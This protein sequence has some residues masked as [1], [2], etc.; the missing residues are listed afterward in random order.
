MRQQR[1]LLGHGIHIPQLQQLL[2]VYLVELG[3]LSIHDSIWLGST[4]HRDSAT[5]RQVLVLVIVG[6][7]RCGPLV[8]FYVHFVILTWEL[9]L[10]WRLFGALIHHEA[11]FL[12]P[13]LHSGLIFLPEPF[14]GFTINGTEVMMRSMPEL[15]DLLLALS[16]VACHIAH[17]TVQ[18]LDVIE[19]L[20]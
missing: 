19:W 15:L 17:R 11:L 10:F 6:G 13:L 4:S 16:A 3:S 20:H 8:A 14:D 12:E 7:L 5:I 2:L 1:L 18:C 9:L